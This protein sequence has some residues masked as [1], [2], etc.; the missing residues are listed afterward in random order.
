LVIASI[1]PV[2]AQADNRSQLSAATVAIVLVGDGEGLVT[3]M[4]AAISI[5]PEGV[6]LVPFHILKDAK[7]VQVRLKSGEIFDDVS[8]IAADERRD[9]AAIK[10]Q[11]TDLPVSPSAAAEELRAGDNLIIV[12]HKPGA[13]WSSIVGRLTASSI[14][15]Q[16]VP[17]AG[18]GFKVIQFDSELP[19]GI[20]G[21]AVF[22]QDGALIGLMTAE[23]AAP[24]NSGFAVP[25]AVVKGLASGGGSARSYGSGKAL[26]MPTEAA[27][28]AAHNKSTDPKDLLLTSKTVYV[29]SN[30]T[31]FKEQQLIN[32]LNKRKEIKQWGWVFVTGS[33]D[34]RNKADLIIELDHQILSFDFTFSLRHRKSSI[35]ISA[36]KAIIAD[37]ASGAPK[38][39]DKIIKS[40]SQILDPPKGK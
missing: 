18:E 3:D 29:T 8:L 33:W 21:A 40:V 13:T 26:K 19:G 4:A 6:L 2:Q 37:G 28:K 15:A 5:K 36:G 27:L 31:Y 30:T 20:E 11:T 7:E 32:E 34:T 23:N 1:S 25:V 22:R 9:V 10:I 39:A 17:G 35:V 14:M 24:A 38:M 12:S 16:E